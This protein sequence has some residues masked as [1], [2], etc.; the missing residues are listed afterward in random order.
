MEKLGACRVLL[1]LHDALEPFEVEAQMS[2]GLYIAC[3]RPDEPSRP[4][5]WE[6][7]VAL[8][9][10]RPPALSEIPVNA[11]ELGFRSPENVIYL[12]RLPGTSYEAVVYNNGNGPGGRARLCVS[13]FRG[14]FGLGGL[15]CVN[16][17]P[18]SVCVDAFELQDGRVSA[19]ATWA[20]VPLSAAYASLEWADQKPRWNRVRGRVAVVQAPS[21]RL[22]SFL[23]TAY[24]ISGAVVATF[25]NR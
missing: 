6:E 2:D 21:P 25:T 20:F 22:D 12:G 7:A 8:D 16:D 24:D 11:S 17:T 19:A 3:L 15:A 9:V 4:G 23:F 5:P 14:R 10:S 1:R 18:T 13:L